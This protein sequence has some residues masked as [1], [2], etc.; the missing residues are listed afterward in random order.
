M[1]GTLLPDEVV[2]VSAPPDPPPSRLHPEEQ[3]LAA[4]MGETRRREFA[5]GRACAHAALDRLGASGPVLRERRM[6]VWPAGVVG[7][8][9]HCPGYC[10]AAVA[11]SGALRSLGIDAEQDAPLSLRAMHRICTPDEIDALAA[12]GGDAPERWA[13]LVFSAKE[14]FYKAWF[15]LTGVFLGFRDVALRIDPDC[16]GFEVRLL[17]DVP[18]VP[19]GPRAARGRYALA[20]PHVLTA[21]TVPY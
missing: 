11:R 10:A 9:T 1:I 5:L 16:A 12:L 14:A 17:R 18:D 15:P 20:P 2:V 8:L 7:S 13:K 3:A 19:D 6:P 21:L 4:E